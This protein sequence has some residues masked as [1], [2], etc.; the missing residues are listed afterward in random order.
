MLLRRDEGHLAREFL[1]ADEPVVA[2][3]PPKVRPPHDERAPARSLEGCAAVAVAA[4]AD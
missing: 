4:Q 1:A 3:R 2:L